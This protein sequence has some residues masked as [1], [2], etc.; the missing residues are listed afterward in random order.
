MRLSLGDATTW[1][2][3]TERTAAALVVL[4]RDGVLAVT[5]AAAVVAARAAAVTAA[6][7]VAVEV[8]GGVAE[9][10]R[11]RLRRD[12]AVAIDDGSKV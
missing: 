8:G 4:L 5:V 10:P 9:L 6:E 12:R 3:G 11:L 7:S 1:T 2:V